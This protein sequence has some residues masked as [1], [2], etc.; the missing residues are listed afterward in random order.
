[1]LVCAMFAWLKSNCMLK[2]L[3]PF[4]IIAFPSPLTC[5]NENP[6]RLLLFPHSATP[7]ITNNVQFSIHT[8]RAARAKFLSKFRTLWRSPSFV[9]AHDSSD[10][11]EN[12]YVFMFVLRSSILKNMN[13]HSRALVFQKS[14]LF[15]VQL[16]F[17]Y[18]TW[19]VYLLSPSY[20]YHFWA[21]LFGVCTHLTSTH[22]TRAI[23]WHAI[24]M[25]SA[26][27]RIE[28]SMVGR[29]FNSDF[30]FTNAGFT[31][32]RLSF[33]Y[34]TKEA[35]KMRASKWERAA[36]EWRLREKRIFLPD[37]RI[38]RDGVV[39]WNK[40]NCKRLFAFFLMR[41]DDEKLKLRAAPWEDFAAYASE[42]LFSQTVVH[43]SSKQSEEE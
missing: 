26:A 18:Q 15:R 27:W 19:A 41:W 30:S 12:A 25:C 9:V 13:S 33:L 11:Q 35:M 21:L 22:C 43:S 32:L 34:R 16:G 10:S 3:F 6:R 28:S 23:A 38:V 37:S 39:A 4:N 14:S 20:Y 5:G 29:S 7:F 42:I 2:R 36:V 8:A 1:M 31:F 24:K 17:S 40:K